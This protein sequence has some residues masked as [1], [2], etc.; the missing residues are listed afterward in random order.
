MNNF[1]SIVGYEAEKKELKRLC[2]VMKNPK[3]YLTLGAK[4]PKAI[5]LEGEPGLGKT[6]MAKTLI[7]ESGRSCF[8]CKKDRADANFVDKIRETFELASNNQPSIVFLDDM[9]KFAQDNLRED[10]N[11]EE[12]VVIQS[13]LE[14]IKDKDIFVIATANDSYI[15]PASLLREGRFGKRLIISTPKKEDSLKIIKHFLKDKNLED[16][17]T[18][19]FI[20]NFVEDKSCAYL[21]ACINEAALYSGFEN[22]TKISRKNI[23]DAIMYFMSKSQPSNNISKEEKLKICFHEAGHAVAS[24]LKGKKVALLSARRYGSLGGFCS[25]FDYEKTHSYEEFRNE[26]SILLAGK[27]GVEIF[28]NTVDLGVKND[29]SEAVE[30]I[31]HHLQELAMEG[32]NYVYL[33]HKYHEKQSRKRFEEVIDKTS[34]ILEEIYKET[35]SLLKKNAILLETIA[36]TLN[37]KEILV[38][39]EI[40]NIVEKEK[41]VL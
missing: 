30:L 2:D 26:I 7:A 31:K 10:S 24:L 13:C 22:K 39:D 21:E 41:V 38:W 34:E 35:V 4:M 12:F 40:L 23:I 29:I 16:D 36:K 5:L 19:E 33:E 37:E 25:T 9:D 20:A 6:L 18:P 3:K 14:D 32:F 17:V 11:K 15:I 27:A 8:A 28:F 1:D